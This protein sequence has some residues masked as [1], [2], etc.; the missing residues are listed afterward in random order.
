MLFNGKR[1][2]FTI[3]NFRV[4]GKNV[5]MKRGRVEAVIHE[6]HNAVLQ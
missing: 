6:V 2:D 5:P 4:Y 3:E 1:D